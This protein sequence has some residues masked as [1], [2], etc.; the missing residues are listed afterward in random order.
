MTKNLKEQPTIAFLFK[1]SEIMPDGSLGAVHIGEFAGDRD[2]DLRLTL[3]QAATLRDQLAG[4]LA[5][6]P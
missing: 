1:R 2:K 3:A 6:Q 5:R 4:A